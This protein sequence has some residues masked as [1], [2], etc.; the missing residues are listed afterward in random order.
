MLFRSRVDE[1]GYYE[2]SARIEVAPDAD[3]RQENNEVRNY[4]YLDGPGKVLLVR[5]SV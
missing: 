1:P 5:D 4:L 2:Y 3:S